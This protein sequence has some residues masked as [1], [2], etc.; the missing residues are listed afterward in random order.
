MVRAWYHDGD[1]S[2]PGEPH[3]ET[4]GQFLSVQ[5][6][7]KEIGVECI[8]VGSH[9]NMTPIDFRCKTEHRLIVAYFPHSKL[10]VK[11]TRKGERH[12]YY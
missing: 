2:T 5:Q 6:L 3:M 10:L 4:P 12:A 11:T 1:T 8:R 9:L 7:R